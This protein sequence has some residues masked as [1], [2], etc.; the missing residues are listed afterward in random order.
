M[1]RTAYVG[2]AFA[3][4]YAALQLV[5]GVI[6]R[7]AWLRHAGDEPHLP[8]RD[9]Q[10]SPSRP[11]YLGA[12]TSSDRASPA[13]SSPAACSAGSASSRSSPR[14]CRNRDRGAARQAGVLADVARP[15]AYGWDPSTHT[16]RRAEHGF[17]RAYVRQIGAGAVAA[18]G[19]ITLLKTLPTRL[20]LPRSVA[21]LRGGAGEASAERTSRD[22]PI[23]VVLIGSLAL[24]LI[25]SVLP[26]LPG[27]L[28]DGSFSA[29]SSS[30]SASSS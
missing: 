20:R 27:N 28:A 4:V 5:F 2:L 29:C 10:R 11:K 12:A 21:S 25:I 19:F 7:D 3:S 8:G 23:G 6:A 16:F 1:A 17:Y 18:G 30:S 14:S 13:S 26:F 9:R 15:G 24:A 22:L